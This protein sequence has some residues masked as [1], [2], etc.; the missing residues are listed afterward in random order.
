MRDFNNKKD[1][2]EQLNSTNTNTYVKSEFAFSRAS[3]KD[4]PEKE[5]SES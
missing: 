3:D 2:K 5:I 1:L 4:T